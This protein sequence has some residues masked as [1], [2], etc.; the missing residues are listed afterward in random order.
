MTGPLQMGRR[1]QALVRCAGLSP[2]RTSRPALGVEDMAR[3]PPL[4]NFYAKL[5]Q[6][7]EVL[8]LDRREFVQRHARIAREGSVTLLV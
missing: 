4:V 2:R 5:V 3:K 7:A 8:I 6:A 1:L